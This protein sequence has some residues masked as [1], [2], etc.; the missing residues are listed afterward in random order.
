MWICLGFT[1]N[2]DIEP[3]IQNEGV[4]E[5]LSF[6]DK[7]Q[8]YKSCLKNSFVLIVKQCLTFGFILTIISAW[9]QKIQNKGE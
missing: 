1:P 4:I 7:K 5:S 2:L 3:I 9:G 8:A 6:C